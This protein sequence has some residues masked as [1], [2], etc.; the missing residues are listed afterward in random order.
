M[1][2]DGAGACKVSEAVQR[3]FME[4]LDEFAGKRFDTG[5]RLF[6]NR[7]TRAEYE[8]ARRIVEVRAQ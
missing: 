5:G 7:K 6:W 3:R 8:A 4:V 2:N 1:R